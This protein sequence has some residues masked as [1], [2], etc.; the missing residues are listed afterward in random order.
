M[1]DS[2]E[3]KAPPP[4]TRRP[5]VPLPRKSVPKKESKT[6]SASNDAVG[7][8]SKAPLE[9]KTKGAYAKI[10]SILGKNESDK[11]KLPPRPSLGARPTKKNSGKESRNY[12]AVPRSRNSKV[13][14]RKKSDSDESNCDSRERMAVPRVPPPSPQ[15]SPTGA[16]L[17]QT[18][19]GPKPTPTAQGNSHDFSYKRSHSQHDHITSKEKLIEA[20]QKALENSIR[21]ELDVEN[22]KYQ[23]AS[24][25]YQECLNDID[26]VL[27]TPLRKLML[28]P[29]DKLEAER[30]MQEMKRLRK[31]VLQGFSDAQTA[32]CL[33]QS[34]VQ[35]PE[36]APP[37]YNDVLMEDLLEN[38]QE[39]P[40]DIPILQP[41]S[42]HETTKNNTE[43]PCSLFGFTSDADPPTTDD[44]SNLRHDG[45]KQVVPATSVKPKVKTRLPYSGKQEFPT[46]VVVPREQTTSFG[47]D[48]A[49]K[50]M[51][52]DSIPDS[53]FVTA[54]STPI[55]SP[56]RQTRSND[57]HATDLL[58]KDVQNHLNKEN[59]SIDDPFQNE[60][61]FAVTFQSNLNNTHSDIFADIKPDASTGKPPQEVS[62]LSDSSFRTQVVYSPSNPFVK[63]ITSESVHNN[64]KTPCVI[65][66]T[67]NS[68]DL[69]GEL[70]YEVR[71][72]FDQVDYDS[73]PSTFE[74]K[75]TMTPL[76][77]TRTVNKQQVTVQSPLGI[78]AL[79]EIERTDTKTAE[80][81][82][83]KRKKQAQS[84]MN[85]SES[86]EKES[87]LP[88]RHPL[89]KLKKMSRS[90]ES[91]LLMFDPIKASSDSRC[92]SEQN[93][94]AIK[95]HQNE[96]QKTVK[97]S[98][99]EEE[100]E[101][102]AEKCIS[103][104]LV[105]VSSENVGAERSNHSREGSDVESS[106][107]NAG[108]S[109][110]YPRLSA[111]EVSNEVEESDFSSSSSNSITE[112]HSISKTTAILSGENT[113]EDFDLETPDLR[114]ASKIQ[115]PKP[116]RK[117]IESN[118]SKIRA[119]EKSGVTI[120]RSAFYA[121]EVKEVN[122]PGGCDSW[123]PVFCVLEAVKLFFLSDSRVTA[124][125]NRQT[126]QLLK[127][128]S[129]PPGSRTTE[130]KV[131]LEVGG[132]LF[133]RE[134][135]GKQTRV[136]MDETGAY[137]IESSEGVFVCLVLTSKVEKAQIL[138]MERM[139]EIYTNLAKEPRS[140]N[141]GNNNVDNAARNAL[142][143]MQK[144]MP[145]IVKTNSMRAMKKI[146]GAIGKEEVR[147]ELS[148]EFMTLKDASVTIRDARMRKA[149]EFF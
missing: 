106:S 10:K 78:K 111:L 46:D 30:T 101:T 113:S 43:E 8:T 67:S 103:K 31:H 16:A 49:S 119:K 7:E 147:Q 110:L 71:K 29:K 2:T 98:D 59:F 96:A 82:F 125:F 58:L 145:G 36:E 74:T 68:T 94:N 42:I 4:S 26:L 20:S 131:R 81:H 124:P 104:P 50:C 47:A 118:G 34:M 57:P 19:R 69:F 87:K 88:N 75:P 23:E 130:G 28:S 107:I 97:F 44:R 61:P 141:T 117:K 72:Q 134:L 27:E 17:R 56:F 53:D 40:V 137:I 121:E 15:T 6:I 148:K 54:F 84:V 79:N 22:S 132:E 70:A 21:A 76:P 14:E 52:C 93:S 38:N 85:I 105:D 133:A 39:I 139:F 108:N 32:N 115:P 33:P 89:T 86:V 12:G 48:R 63:D 73:S 77:V 62:F 123:L 51:S 95:E 116:V 18:S 64:G 13:H 120:G 99:E 102:Q 92:F 35:T 142:K 138:E 140:F 146:R 100:S 109:S 91:L 135:Q 45:K 41:T 90:N 37:S 60:N 25:K 112:E 9:S 66:S 127:K 122:S 3:S 65:S 1:E 83:T 136:L 128:S 126:L 24:K 55:V 149:V 11:P 80:D 129:P 114:S 144:K 143:V 5:P